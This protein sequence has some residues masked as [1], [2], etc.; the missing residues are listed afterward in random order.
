MEEEES[1]GHHTIKIKKMDRVQLLTLLVA[2]T[3]VLQVISMFGGFQSGGAPTGNVVA[4]SPSPST[5]PAPAPSPVVNVK[6]GEAPVEGS[7]KAKVEIIEYSDYECP[8]CGRFYSE[9]LPQI[10]AQYIET[11]KVKHVFKDFPLSFHP[12]AQKA[13]EAAHCVREQAGDEAYFE[14]HDLL[15]NNQQ[16]L[17]PAGYKQWARTISG[18][19]G[20]EFDSCLDSGKTAGIVRANFQEG[21]QVGVQG[22]PAFF[23]NGRLIS[24]AQPFQVFQQAIEAEL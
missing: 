16:S 24:G 9:T 5:S 13:A 4:P 14:M 20:A 23:V 22:T 8:F 17:S 10:R 18:V 3:L 19:D 1:Q 7:A 11:G 6:A 21:G 12:N 15:F 2:A